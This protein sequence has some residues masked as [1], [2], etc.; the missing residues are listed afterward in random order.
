MA[1]SG[2]SGVKM[3]ERC[4][5]STPLIVGVTNPVHQFLTLIECVLQLLLEAIE[6]R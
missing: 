6:K 5:E 1:E 4:W 2:N 3:K